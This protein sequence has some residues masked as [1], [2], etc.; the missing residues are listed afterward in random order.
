MNRVIPSQSQ[1]FSACIL[2]GHQVAS[3][4]NGD[5][6]FPGGTLRM[7]SPYFLK[8][9]LDLSPFYLGTLNVSI[10]PLTYRIIRPRFTF[11]AVK[12][13]PIEPAEDFSFFDIRVQCNDRSPVDGLIYYPHPET[14]P[15]HFQPP[16]VLELL[17]SFIDGLSVGSQLQLEVS[18]EQMVVESK[19]K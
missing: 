1:E 17:L 12:W 18:A 15:M 2:R 4:A 13:H 14:K 7:Q 11:R 5:A 9:G 10:A 3:G 19:N 6:R 8:L 16:D